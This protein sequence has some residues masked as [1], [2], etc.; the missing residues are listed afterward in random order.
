VKV[1]RSGG[2]EPNAGRRLLAW[3]R[4]AGFQREHIQVTSAVGVYA[5]RARR[6]FIANR[7]AG[8]LLQSDV[9]TKA[10]EL[11]LTTK[12]EIDA[13]ADAWKTWVEDDNGYLGMT[14]TEILAFKE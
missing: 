5:T 6:Q 12:K 8:G 11:G 14:D 4:E 10:I 3:A 13:I 9:G 1:I 7:F 2:S